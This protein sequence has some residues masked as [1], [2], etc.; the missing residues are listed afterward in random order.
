AA[1]EG[2][3]H[4]MLLIEPDHYQHLLADIGLDSADDLLA[5]TATRLT[6]AVE[7]LDAIVA[8][9]GEHTLALLVRNSDHEGTQ[10]VANRVLAAFSADLFEIGSRSSVI[11]A[12]I[13]AVQVGEKIASVSQVLAKATQAVAS[14][15]ATG[16][17]RFE[18]F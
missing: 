14:A 8:R 2:A 6:A 12:S 11:T 15:S 17:N 16:G 4:G 5:A 10:A 3:R 18:L 13:G 1:Q 9:F 7:G